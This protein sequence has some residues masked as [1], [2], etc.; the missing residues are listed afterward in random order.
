MERLP[1]FP[2]EETALVDTVFVT[3]AA[4]TKSA[5]FLILDECLPL[6]GIFLVMFH[7]SKTPLD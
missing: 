7:D 1:L 5:V 3:P 4:D 6:L 2:I